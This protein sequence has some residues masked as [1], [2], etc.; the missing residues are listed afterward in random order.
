LFAILGEPFEGSRYLL[1]W[2][3]EIV[4]IKTICFCGSKATMNIRIDGS[5]H[6]ITSG[7]QVQI[8]GNES[9][10]SSCM[11]HF[12]NSVKEIDNHANSLP[13]LNHTS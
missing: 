6:A 1:A 7:E 5:G 8:G 3:Q 4:E 11:Y 10:I 12:F 2:S 9:Y 13:S